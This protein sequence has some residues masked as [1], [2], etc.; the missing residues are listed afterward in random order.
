[1]RNIFFLLLVLN[2]VLL[3]AQ[4]KPEAPG[5][6]FLCELKIKLNPAM[7]V[8]ETPHGLR[9]IIP[10]IGGTV[11]GPTIKG[12]ILSG[13]SDWQIVRKD[14]V[15]ELEAHYQFKTEDGVLIYIKNIGLRVASPEVAAKI[16]KGEFVDPKEYYFRAVP[17]F[18]APLGKYHYLNNAI[19][20]CKGIR[21]PDNVVIEVWQV[22]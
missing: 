7:I 12:E 3:S 16:G 6:E 21:N 4:T 17:K 14:G 5:L 13:G 11:S 22:K 20:I 8:G 2:S 18:E 1:M 9:R 19:F 15:A 10:I